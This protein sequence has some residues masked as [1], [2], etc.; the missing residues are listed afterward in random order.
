MALL[1][2]FNANNNDIIIISA[3]P[4]NRVTPL[5]GAIRLVPFIFI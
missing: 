2:E 4:D 5:L 1:K 3:G